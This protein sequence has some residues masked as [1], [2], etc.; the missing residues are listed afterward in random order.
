M[1]RFFFSVCPPYLT[2]CYATLTAHCYIYFQEICLRSILK[3]AE[4]LTPHDIVLHHI[5][6]HHVTPRLITLNQIT[7][8]YISL[9]HTTLY[10][11]TSHSIMLYLITLND[12]TSHYDTT[13]H[14]SDNVT[15]QNIPLH[16]TPHLIT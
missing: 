2:A 6:L 7:S 10:Q 12:I 3:N 16:I 8:C 13:H 15:S 9:Q 14:V 11:N 5:T 1:L 4:L